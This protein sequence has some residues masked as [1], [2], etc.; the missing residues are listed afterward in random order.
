VASN[1]GRDD[2]IAI[3][4]DADLWLA[5]LGSGESVSHELASGRHAWI[6]IAEGGVTVNG[7]TLNAG[8][9]GIVDEAISLKFTATKPS[10]VLLFDLT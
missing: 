9:A 2:S 4:Q 10:Q 6:H 5:K 3:R 7:K 8:D 1:D